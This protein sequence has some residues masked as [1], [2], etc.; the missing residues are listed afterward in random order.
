MW[1][2]IQTSCG[3]DI[4]QKH[5]SHTLP[6]EEIVRAFNGWR[7]KWEINL[8]PVLITALLLHF[9]WF[10]VHYDHRAHRVVLEC[11]GVSLQTVLNQQCRWWHHS[12]CRDS[13]CLSYAGSMTLFFFLII[14]CLG[15]DVKAR[16][17]FWLQLE[18]QSHRAP[19][20]CSVVSVDPVGLAAATS[21]YWVSAGSHVTQNRWWHTDLLYDFIIL[22][23]RAHTFWI[24]VL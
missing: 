9:R 11:Y 8:S 23:S 16:R 2:W 10:S 14:S 18:P 6:A 24:N 1:K 3:P 12:C 4:L 5:P 22:L 21:G 15:W 13:A 17:P 7:C 19:S 20:G